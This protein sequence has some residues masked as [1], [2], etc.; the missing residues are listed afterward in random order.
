MKITLAGFNVDVEILNDIKSKSE[1][2]SRDLELRN[3]VNLPEEDLFRIVEHA[4]ETVQEI[5]N[6]NNLTPEVLSA[7]YARISRNPQPI[8][9][10]RQAAREGISRARRS[11]QQIIFGLGHKSVAEHAVFNFDVV[12]ISRLATEFIQSNRLCSF[13]EK[14]QR[15]VRFEE[16]VYLPAELTDSS[17][18]QRFTAV[19]HQQFALYK[20]LVTQIH[21]HLLKQ[22][23]DLS[24]DESAKH[25]LENLAG[26]DARYILPLATYTQF[27]MTI[28]ARALEWMAMKASA[29]PLREMRDFGEELLKFANKYAPSLVKYTEASDDFKTTSQRIHTYLPETNTPATNR[30]GQRVR[31]LSYPKNGDDHLLAMLL[32]SHSHQPLKSCTKI[33]K[34]FAKDRKLSL[35]KDIM[36]GLTAHDPVWREFETLNFDFEI[37]LSASAYAQLK[38]HRMSTQLVQSFNP[39][40]GVVIPNSIKKI[41]LQESFQSII[42]ESESIF[43]QLESQF[44]TIK[45]YILTNSHCHRVLLHANARELYHIARLRM[46]QSAQWE[47]RDIA[48]EILTAASQQC[49]LT[50]SLACGKDTFINLHE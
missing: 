37:I 5:A 6:K 33:I 35:F 43:H 9:E 3:L 28:N 8:S 45:E 32:F 41:G 38:R 30:V 18:R 24:S 13:T 27:G 19:V 20:K 4:A 36:K 14:S 11:N 39:T 26:E 21:Q 40:L 16:N 31:C 50:F 23:P 34:S 10:I 12:D 1:N 25:Q 29:H 44:P 48:T 7:A 47:I 42:E 49:P 15:Y 46:D 2:I 22:N 17:L